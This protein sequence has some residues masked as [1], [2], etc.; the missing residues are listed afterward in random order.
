MSSPG[1]AERRSTNH[2]F[3]LQHL[4]D[5]TSNHEQCNKDFHGEPRGPADVPQLPTRVLSLGTEIDGEIKLLEQNPDPAGPLHRGHYTALSHCWGPK[6][7]HSITTTTKNIDNHRQ[8]ISFKVLSRTLQDAV[9][10]TRN[11][12]LKYLWIDSL[13]I[14]QD[15][16]EDW[17]REAPTMG[18]VYEEAY[19]TICATGAADGTEGCF[20]VAELDPAEPIV[21]DD[22][23]IGFMH[24]AE[25][26]KHD[27]LGPLQSR[28]WITQEWILSRRQIHY[29][30]GRLAWCCDEVQ[31]YDDGSTVKVV[32]RINSDFNQGTFEELPDIS[33]DDPRSEK[34][35]AV[36]K[37]IVQ[38]FTERDLTVATDKL[39][40]ISG[41]IRKIVDGD[42]ARCR[43]GVMMDDLPY[44]LLWSR[45][46]NE[47]YL[48]RPGYLRAEGIPSWSWASTEG[49]VDYAR[50]FLDGQM[51]KLCEY[52][53]EPEN[54]RLVLQSGLAYS[55]SSLSSIR[56][57]RSESVLID[58]K[59]D[60]GGSITGD[61]CV[62]LVV[63]I[64]HNNADSGC[65][66]LILR[67]C[68]EGND[69]FER[70]GMAW[71]LEID[72]L[73]YGQPEGGSTEDR[74]W[75]DREIFVI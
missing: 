71:D 27:T 9:T 37:W 13:C 73:Y 36:W 18:S 12:G 19:L 61:D 59:D 52:S 46:D 62:Y 43:Y 38:E 39:A 51:E 35:K 41:L 57:D 56:E 31:Q 30:R 16:K 6:E 44:S 58:C 23:N 21:S 11:L 68:D 3:L 1:N 66:C 28:A 4:E 8:S 2:R 55:K 24:K 75:S 7:K 50:P 69:V 33:D 29:C 60:L 65:D 22:I 54:K 48:K 5:C 32:L 49:K 26:S 74:S 67:K 70:I 20:E 15:C 45:W 72:A 47:V 53:Y 17:E 14:I 63:P 10:I 25:R 64:V 40:A 34:V 42:E